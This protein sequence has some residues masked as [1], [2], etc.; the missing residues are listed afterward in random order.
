[1][2]TKHTKNAKPDYHIKDE[3]VA[4]VNP[5]NDA[6]FGGKLNKDFMFEYTYENILRY[7]KTPTDILRGEE[8]EG[9]LDQFPFEAADFDFETKERISGRNLVYL[10]GKETVLKTFKY[11]F[12]KK[13]ND[14]RD[15]QLEVYSIQNNVKEL[16][17]IRQHT[18]NYFAKCKG[19]FINELEERVYLMY[20]FYPHCLE[21]FIRN[22]S[23]NMINKVKLIKLILE[24][25]KDIHREGIIS[26]NLSIQS[27]R[28][29]N[30]LK[31]KIVSFGNSLDMASKYDVDRKG[32]ITKNNDIFC[33]PEIH[34]N[35]FSKLGWHADIWSL[36]MIIAMLF[37]NRIFE[38][39][40][41]KIVNFFYDRDLIPE[42]FFTHIENV[43][44]K[45]LVIGMLRLEPE[46]RPNIFEVIDMFNHFIDNY[47]FDYGCHLFYTK[48]DVLSK[49]IYLFF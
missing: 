12:D 43:H 2:G 48:D 25:V 9:P 10:Y 41:G 32:V 26:L 4:L 23:L 8:I 15:H 42:F 49:I 31:L 22:E 36:G 6:E 21:E 1:M 34:L 18:S 30:D 37:S 14:D 45:A 13:G 44:V 33:P 16:R 3:F 11:G 40:I 29:S 46:D 28:F 38:E 5:L 35:K 47:E 39:E 20:D 24:C 27:L 7:M 17:I 19:F